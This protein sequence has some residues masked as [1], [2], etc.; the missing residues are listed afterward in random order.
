VIF[1][2]VF[3]GE[4]G[5]CGEMWGN[6]GICVEMWG[7]V[8]ICGETWGLWRDPCVENFGELREK[9]KKEKVVWPIRAS[10]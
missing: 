4:C 3:V 8:G 10:H 5:V 1:C 6:V 7:I 2:E 9:L